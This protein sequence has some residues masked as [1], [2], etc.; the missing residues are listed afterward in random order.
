MQQ[1][2]PIR[3]YL[4]VGDQETDV[5]EGKMSMIAVNRQMR[6]LLLNKGYEVA[7]FEFNGGHDYDC[8]RKT[9]SN[10]LRALFGGKEKQPLTR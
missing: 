9:F 1:H 10:G 5:Y 3:F 6:D 8:W 2:S 7:Y 4:D